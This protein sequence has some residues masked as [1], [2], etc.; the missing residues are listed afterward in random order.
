MKWPRI[1]ITSDNLRRRVF[2]PSAYSCV[3]IVR[4][5]ELV[6]LPETSL[7]QNLRVSYV[8][9]PFQPFL[10]LP[11]RALRIVSSFLSL[12]WLQFPSSK[13]SCQTVPLGLE[14]EPQPS[15]A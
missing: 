1:W 11:L 3:L 10:A 6:A 5:R 9:I 8:D 12:L 15:T 7:Y 4:W 14:D 13:N 2:S